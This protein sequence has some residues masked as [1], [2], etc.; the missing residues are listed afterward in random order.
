MFLKLSI[1][2][3][4]QNYQWWE[5]SLVLKALSNFLKNIIRELR[6]ACYSATYDKSHHMSRFIH[7][8][9]LFNSQ[10]KIAACFIGMQ[11]QPSKVLF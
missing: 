1:V 3:R 2:C 5:L 11:L 10:Q 9:H 4:L 6:G 8:L 7:L